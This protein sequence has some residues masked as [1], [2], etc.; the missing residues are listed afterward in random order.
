LYRVFMGI[1]AGDSKRRLTACESKTKGT[2]NQVR[3]S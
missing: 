3:P 2:D 1:V